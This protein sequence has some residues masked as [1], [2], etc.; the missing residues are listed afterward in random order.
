MPRYIY[1]YERYPS[2]VHGVVYLMSSQVAERLYDQ[3]L[4][5]EL[6]HLEDVFLTGLI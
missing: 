1:P 6:I 2:Y 4:Q 5:N 3:S